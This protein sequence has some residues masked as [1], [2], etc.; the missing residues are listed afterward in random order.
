MKQSKQRHLD[1]RRDGQIILNGIG[2][3]AA[4]IVV[5][6]LTAAGAWWHGVARTWPAIA[7]VALA[8]LF[9]AMLSLEILFVRDFFRWRTSRQALA[10]SQRPESRRA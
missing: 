7:W 2:L 5:V 10:A 9:V 1:Q 6:A 8:L 3:G 4:V